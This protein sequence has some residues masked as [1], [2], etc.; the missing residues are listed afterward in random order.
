MEIQ[1]LTLLDQDRRLLTGG[2][3]LD[4]IDHAPQAL[5]AGGDRL[6]PCALVRGFARRGFSRLKVRFAS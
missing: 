5:H 4:G 1:R 6:G 2:A 3:N